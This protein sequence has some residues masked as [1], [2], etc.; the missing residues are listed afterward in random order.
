[1]FHPEI[2]NVKQP[3]LMGVSHHTERQVGQQ[4]TESDGKQ[5]QRLELFPDGKIKQDQRN[6]DHHPLARLDG[7]EAGGVS[8]FAD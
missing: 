8:N 4:A 5:K 3:A 1:M 2:E 7:H 6:D